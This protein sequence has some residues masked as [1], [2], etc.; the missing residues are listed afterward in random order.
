MTLPSS[1]GIDETMAKI[2]VQPSSDNAVSL[3]REARR[4]KVLLGVKGNED[5]AASADI[6]LKNCIELHHV[7][8]RLES[9]PEIVKRNILARAIAGI[10]PVLNTIEEFRSMEDKAP[11]DIIMNAMGVVSELAQA[12]QYLEAT[13]LSS[14]AKSEEALIHVEQ[15][16]V[17]LA[18]ETPGDPEVELNSVEQFIDSVRGLQMNPRDR[19]FVPFMLWVFISIISYKRLKEQYE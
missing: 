18:L 19:P 15:R 1:K 4:F 16:L 2:L 14:L 7:I 9:V 12:T 17:E 6:H 8:L 13:R 5:L 10:F 3:I 11:F